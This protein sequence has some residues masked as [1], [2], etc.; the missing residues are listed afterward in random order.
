[1]PQYYRFNQHLN[2]MINFDEHLDPAYRKGYNAAG[3]TSQNLEEAM[4]ED[5]NFSHVFKRVNSEYLMTS[6]DGDFVNM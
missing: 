2:M 5:S 6:E 1:M 3:S 4:L